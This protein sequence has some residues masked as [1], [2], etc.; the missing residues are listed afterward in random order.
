[1]RSNRGETS[2]KRRR[3]NEDPM[4]EFDR[5][6]AEL[7]AWLANA[8]LPWR[9][10][11][12]RSAFAKAV[13]RTQDKA[14]ALRELDRLQARLVARDARQVWGTDHPCAEAPIA[15]ADRANCHTSGRGP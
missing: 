11:S 7:R 4:Q 10:R 2:L 6:P 8:V 3:R 15:M 1:M 13:A 5:L 12:V 14:S 9:P